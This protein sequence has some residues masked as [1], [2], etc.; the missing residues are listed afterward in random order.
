MDSLI[1]DELKQRFYDDTRV[2]SLLPML[3][4]KLMSGEITAVRAAAQLLDIHQHQQSPKT[5]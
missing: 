1:Q 2:L 5:P 4:G 3:R